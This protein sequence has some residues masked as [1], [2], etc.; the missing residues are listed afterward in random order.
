MS[1]A[2]G[3]AGFEVPGADD[4]P[5]RGDARVAEQPSGAV[6]FCHGFMGF[7][8]VAYGKSFG[9]PLKLDR[10][11]IVAAVVEAL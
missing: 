8:T 6:V 7:E 5:I 1:R 2:A 4:R 9:R 3:I 11:T 10:Q